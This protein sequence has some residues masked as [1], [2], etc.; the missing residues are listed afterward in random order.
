MKIFWGS[1]WLTEHSAAT[2]T[3]TAHSTLR[4]HTGGAGWRTSFTETCNQPL[5]PISKTWI[6]VICQQILGNHPLYCTGFREDSGKCPTDF[7]LSLTSLAPLDS[8]QRALQFLSPERWCFHGG[9][10]LGV[11]VD[12]KY[13]VNRKQ[14]WFVQILIWKACIPGCLHL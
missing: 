14:K 2:A 6:L 10:G 3:H 11:G 9:L 5:P 13:T 8:K 4:K 7:S 12:R 1:H